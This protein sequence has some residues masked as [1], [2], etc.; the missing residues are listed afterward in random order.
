L[1][2]VNLPHRLLVVLEGESLFNDASALLIYRLA[3]GAVAT[4]GFEAGNVA[5]VFLLNAF[6]SVALGW[7]LARLY[8]WATES[9]EDHPSAI[10]LQFVATF[11]VWI[12]AEHIA[13]SGIIT[14]VTYGI[15]IARVAPGR[16]S[17]EMR[18]PSYAVWETVVFVLQVLAFMLIGLQLKPI[19]VG[20]T[21][22]QRG[23]YARVALAVLAVVVL[24]RIAWAMTYNTIA[25]SVYRHAGGHSAPQPSHPATFRSGIIV[26]WCGM[27][28]IVTLAAA[29]GLPEAFPYR[30]LILLSSFTVVLGTLV[31][32]GLTLGPLLRWLDLRDDQPVEREA[33]LAARR[34]L[35]AALAAIDGDASEEAKSLRREYRQALEQTQWNRQGSG[36][37]TRYNA[38]RRQAVKAARDVVIKLWQTGQIGDDAFHRVEQELDQIEIGIAAL[39]ERND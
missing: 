15:A 5:P 22:A 12:L 33:T 14:V 6:G 38:L 37:R 28:G 8:L 4:G 21:E 18:I 30:D 36:K 10:V 13:L 1:R 11:G 16:T 32:Q 20:L 26:S 31:I 24:V 2:S 23:E 17:A 7:V 19:L 27:R 34:A 29:Y 25:R 3:V 39:G 9:V 35:Q